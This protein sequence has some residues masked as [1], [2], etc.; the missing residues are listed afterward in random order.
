[1]STT[2]FSGHIVLVDYY[3]TL[4]VLLASVLAQVFAFPEYKQSSSFAS[5]LFISLCS[6]S[7]E[8]IKAWLSLPRENEGNKTGATRAFLAAILIVSVQPTMMRTS[9]FAFLMGLFIYQ[10]FTW[11][12]A[13]DTSAG[14]SGSRNVFIA[15]IVKTGTCGLFFLLAFSSKD[16]IQYWLRKWARQ[17]APSLRLLKVF[18]V[19]GVDSE[20]ANTSATQYRRSCAH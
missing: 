5:S 17:L 10:G 6:S 18:A 16:L 1:M 20:L 3:P 2:L 9:I 4:L 15:F 8:N 14:R 7:P 19:G 12:R 11:T 13:L